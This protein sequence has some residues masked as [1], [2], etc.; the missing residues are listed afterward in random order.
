MQT[1]FHN[2]LGMCVFHPWVSALMLVIYLDYKL[3]TCI[4]IKNLLIEYIQ[5]AHLVAAKVDVI[6]GI[7]HFTLKNPRFCVSIDVKRWWTIEV[8]LITLTPKIFSKIIIDYNSLPI[9]CH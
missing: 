2:D 7:Q 5:L 4:T 3:L 9:R 8:K 6:L 1:L